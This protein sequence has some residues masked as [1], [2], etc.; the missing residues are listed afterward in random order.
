MIRRNTG[1]IPSDRC[2]TEQIRRIDPNWLRPDWYKTERHTEA[3]VKTVV[4]ECGVHGL[5]GED[6]WY[7]LQ[8]TW[9]TDKD[10]SLCRAWSLS[11]NN[12]TGCAYEFTVPTCAQFL[13]RKNTL[14][15]KFGSRSLPESHCTDDCF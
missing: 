12:T 15:S 3:L 2:K 5:A 10:D 6:I 13:S 14:F 4:A 8:L 11:G 7:L 1:K 9:I